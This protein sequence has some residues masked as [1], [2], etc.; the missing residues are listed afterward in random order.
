MSQTIG[1]IIC[2]SGDGSNHLEWFFPELEDSQLE[3]IEE[4]DFERYSSGDGIQYTELSF[5]DEFSL[6][7]WCAANNI[8]PQTYQEWFEENKSYID[9]AKDL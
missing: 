6:Q 4:S 2:N 5:P 7:G 1:F 8:S 3:F 9:W